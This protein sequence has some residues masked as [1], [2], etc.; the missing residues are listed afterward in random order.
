MQ[1]SGGRASKGDHEGLAG[2]ATVTKERSGGDLESLPFLD[3]SLAGAF[4]RHSYLHVPKERV[5]Y[6][7]AESPPA[8]WPALPAAAQ[9]PV[10]AR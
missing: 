9:H 2:S 7:L 1:R 4:A 5:G 6:A 10:E 8:T 3:G